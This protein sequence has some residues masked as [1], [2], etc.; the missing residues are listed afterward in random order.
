M[1]PR[2]LP[3]GAAVAAALLLFGP[4]AVPGA[5]QDDNGAIAA[6]GATAS[7]FYVTYFD[8]ANV[9][10]GGTAPPPDVNVGFSSGNIDRSGSAS[11]IGA[12]AYTPYIDVFPALNALAGTNIDWEPILSRARAAVTGQPPKDAVAS[13][14]TPTA[15]TDVGTAEAHL[16]VGPA[17]DVFTTLVRLEPAPGT[18]IK[19]SASRIKVHKVEGAAVTE[20][21]TLLRSVNIAGLL[22]FDSISL[23]SIASADGGA[24]AADAKVVVEGASIAGTPVALT[25]TGFR[26]ADQTVP[27]DLT[28]LKDQLAQ[29]GIELVGPGSLR[30][31]PGAERSFATA[32]GPRIR[33]RNPQCPAP[34]QREVGC[35]NTIDIVLGHAIASST[36]LP[37]FMLPP[38]PAPPPA[39]PAPFVPPI[40][41]GSTY[42]PPTDVAAAPPPVSAPGTAVVD[43]SRLVLSDE[44]SVDAFTALYSA[45]AAGGM[46]ILAGL[47][48][49]RRRSLLEERL[50]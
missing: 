2:L 16:S 37:G 27:I 47:V 32:T 12:L 33:F 10:Y 17:L 39:V 15:L 6:G 13:L 1:R 35:G 18:H 38:V 14:S 26:V 19:S 7:S 5:A 22:T 11:G 9:L 3:A 8:D 21:T 4:A 50:R 36:L 30:T 49:P 34:V 40:D 46:L 28:P 41:S 24:G 44:K 23:T 29:A 45:L 31:E 42:T 25:E 20:A 48:L 43:V